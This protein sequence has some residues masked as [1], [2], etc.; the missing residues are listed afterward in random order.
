MLLVDF[1]GKLMI[2]RPIVTSACNGRWRKRRSSAVRTL[3]A[4]TLVLAKTHGYVEKIEDELE[5]ELQ[6]DFSDPPEEKLLRWRRTGDKIFKSKHVLLTVV[7]LCIVDC[8]LV[9]GELALDLYKVKATLEDSETLKSATETFMVELTAIHPVINDKSP[10][11]IFAM[12]LGSTVI[13]NTS[14][15]YTSSANISAEQVVLCSAENMSSSIL[16]FPNIVKNTSQLL[17]GD[18]TT[19]SKYDVEIIGEIAHI[20]HYCSIAI[21]AVI[22]IETF[23]KAVCAGRS[24]FHR[25]I[26]VFDAFVVVMSFLMDFTFLVFLHEI[27]TKDFV[28]ILAILLPWRVIR[29]VNSLIVS[30]KDH[31]HFRLK[32]VYKRKKKIQGTLRDTE[33]LLQKYMN[34]STV[35]Q[36]LCIMEGIEEWKLDTYLKSEE[37]V[38][39][40]PVKKKFKFK[41]DDSKFHMQGHNRGKRCSMPSL[42]FHALKLPSSHSKSKMSLP[43]VAQS[44]KNHISKNLPSRRTSL[45]ATEMY[46]AKM[47][48]GDLRRRK[49]A[50]SGDLCTMHEE[51]SEHEDS[52]AS[53]GATSESGDVFSRISVSESIGSD[54]MFGDTKSLSR[55]NSESIED[56]RLKLAKIQEEAKR[57][58]SES[59]IDKNKVSSVDF[60]D[61]ADIIAFK[62]PGGKNITK[63]KFYPNCDSKSAIKAKHSETNHSDYRSADNKAD[64]K[65]SVGVV[66][67]EKDDI[68]TLPCSKLSTEDLSENNNEAVKDR[69]NGHSD[70]KKSDDDAS[71]DANDFICTPHDVIHMENEIQNG[72]IKRK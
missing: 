44:I 10:F 22:M 65:L 54:R 7:I 17:A 28:F 57:R 34:Q 64:V 15:N 26:E 61:L 12:L 43:S 72:T 71:D 51:D 58:H 8:A 52:I 68:N 55:N 23:L 3:V 47:S 37:S 38:P 24:F 62:T 48:N 40:T 39:P 60:H 69:E 42:D 45:A 59:T 5:R 6:R 19:H 50:G 53:S 20:F 9:L 63:R 13:W 33:A 16:S 66:D 29:V 27:D 70:A 14:E 31:E 30:V 56:E 4:E 36:R 18:T 35:L 46:N 1:L 2:K 49:L 67:S 41:F 21:L 11:D 32:L 25:K